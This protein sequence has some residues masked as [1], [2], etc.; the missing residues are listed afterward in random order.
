MNQ[1]FWENKKK[2]EAEMNDEV[3]RVMAI[4]DDHGYE[5]CDHVDFRF[6][7]QFV[8]V[9]TQHE[10][11]IIHWIWAVPKRENF[12]Q[13]LRWFLGH[14]KFYGVTA[15]MAYDGERNVAAGKYRPIPTFY[16]AADLDLYYDEYFGW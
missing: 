16:K 12:R 10:G 13:V 7:H 8:S 14:T 6:C 9:E 1:K 11:R 4:M 15:H 2:H 5:F 3:L